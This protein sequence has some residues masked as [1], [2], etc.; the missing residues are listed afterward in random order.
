VNNCENVVDTVGIF[1]TLI[2][3]VNVIVIYYTKLALRYCVPVY[4]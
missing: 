1:L 2:P 3:F 4:T